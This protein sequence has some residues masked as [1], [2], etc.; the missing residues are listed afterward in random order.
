MYAMRVLYQLSSI[1]GLWRMLLN[2]HSDWTV[3][4]N[5]QREGIAMMV[6]RREI[7][8]SQPAALPGM[9]GGQGG[10]KIL[11]QRTEF[12]NYLGLGDPNC[13]QIIHANL[14]D[15]ETETWRHSRNCP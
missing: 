14:T 5:G 3:D 1:S 9:E 13:S 15:G 2:T 4:S 7:V 11:E 12:G 10:W 8:L 6:C